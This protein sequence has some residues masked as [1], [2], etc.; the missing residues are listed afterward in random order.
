MKN[1]ILLVIFLIVLNRLNAQWAN[2]DGPYGGTVFALTSDGNY[3]YAGTQRGLFRSS[4]NNINWEQLGNEILDIRSIAVSEENIFIGTLGKGVYRSTDY[5]ATWTQAINGLSLPYSNTMI[6]DI[7]ISGDNIYVGYREGLYVS[8][9]NGDSWTKIKSE[10]VFKMEIPRPNN[11]IIY[12]GR[13]KIILSDDNGSSWKDIWNYSKYFGVDIDLAN[14]MIYAQVYSVTSIRSKIYAGTDRGIFLSND[15]GSNWVQTNNGLKNS[16]ITSLFINDEGIYAGSLE[17]GIHFSNNDGN[18]WTQINNG[19]SELE[20]LS[21]TGSQTR[22]FAGTNSGVFMSA[23]N[24]NLWAPINQGITGVSVNSIHF[25]GATYFLSSNY[26]VFKLSDANWTQTN[27][28]ISNKTV[29]SLAAIG[30]KIFVGTNDG[31]YSSSNNGAEWIKIKN[32]I[33]EAFITRL[34]VYEN[35]LFVVA[36]PKEI[37]KTTDLGISWVK[38]NLDSINADENVLDLIVNMG[39]IIVSTYSGKLFLSI[40]DGASWTIVNNNIP[41]DLIFTFVSNAEKIIGISRGGFIF[42]STSNGADWTFDLGA[43]GSNL[44]NRIIPRSLTISNNN[45]FLGSDNGLFLSEDFGHSWIQIGLNN[46]IVLSL[47]VKGDYL[48]AGTEG[49]GIWKRSISEMITDVGYE[50]D[51]S[52]TSFQLFQNYPNPFNPITKIKFDLPERAKT[53]LIVYDILGREVSLLLD[54]ELETGNHEIDFDGSKYS[55]GVYFY[56]I[57][58]GKYSKMMKMILMK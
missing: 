31:L 34:K 39:N 46:K 3:V 55:S 50:E 56:K 48:F 36:S 28:G 53:R 42:T 15:F 20:I 18:N 5:G 37:Y 12:G 41:K 30:E 49:Y 24:G 7:K 17:G 1:K 51:D 44:V 4:V 21:F 57:L 6:R 9:N 54:S 58:S 13:D 16:L 19:L 26:G 14:E 47:F 43:P 23:S 38:L 2:M 22:I 40:D 32:G 45:L 25:S 35:N 52:I 29:S 8:K 10:P 11:L 27:N 33:A